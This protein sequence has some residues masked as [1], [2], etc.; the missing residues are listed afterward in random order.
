MRRWGQINEPK[1]DSWYLDTAKKSFRP[2]V[3]QA[4]AKELVAE[5]KAKASDFPAENDSGFK[6]ANADFIDKVSFD[7]QKPNDYLTHFTI[8][9]KGNQKVVG[10]KIVE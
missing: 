1:P 3:Y 8:G 7:A 9:L 6:A 5:G 10:G 4:A 2:D